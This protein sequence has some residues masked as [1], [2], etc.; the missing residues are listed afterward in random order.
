MIYKVFLRFGEE[1]FFLLFFWKW[2]QS[3]F[4]GEST[5]FFMILSYSH[6]PKLHRAHGLGSAQLKVQTGMGFSH[7]IAKYSAHGIWAVLECW[8]LSVLFTAS[9]QTDFVLQEWK[10]N[11]SYPLPQKTN[12]INGVLEVVFQ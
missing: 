3:I 7:I 2:K 5:V 11:S 8:L 6:A 1:F 4:H 10:T 12:K 9:N